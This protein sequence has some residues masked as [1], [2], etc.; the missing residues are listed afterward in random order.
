MYEYLC[1]AENWLLIGCGSQAVRQSVGT[2]QICALLY[3][4]AGVSNANIV[5]PLH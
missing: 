1:G 2:R 5:V 3:T 4:Y